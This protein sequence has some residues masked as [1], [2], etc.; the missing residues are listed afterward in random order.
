MT[1][2]HISRRHDQGPHI[3]FLDSRGVLAFE[4]H[5]HALVHALEAGQESL[6]SCRQN[7][8]AFAV[9][10]GYLLRSGDDFYAAS[11]Y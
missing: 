11:N 7:L 6:E 4:F 1:R 3:L 5:D 2:I 8:Q 9:R 10:E